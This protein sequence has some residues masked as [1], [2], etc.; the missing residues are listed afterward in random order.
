MTRD[1]AAIL[2]QRLI[3]DLR[4]ALVPALSTGSWD[5]IED[6]H[7]KVDL[8]WRADLKPGWGKPRYVERVLNDLPE[9]EIVRVGQRVVER[10]ADRPV[11]AVEHA[12]LWIAARGVAQV[13][14]ITR[15]ALAS[16]L[17]GQR[18]HPVDDPNVVLGRFACATGT[19]SPTFDYG[20][21][22]DLVKV[23]MNVFGILASGKSSPTT[24]RT[25]HRA[26]LDAYGFRDWPDARLFE[27]LEFLVN[28]TVR[29]GEEQSSL[30]KIL[31]SVLAADR[32]ELVAGEQRLSGHPVFKV[33]PVTGGVTGRPKNL[34]FA[35]TG[36]KPELGF[37][38]AVNNDIVILRHAE[39]CLVYDEPIGDDG[40]RWTRLIEWWSA[41]NAVDP[42]D[43]ATRSQLGERL[44]KSLASEPERRLFM[45]YFKSLRPLL[46]DALPALIPQVYLHYDP[47]TL[48][49]LRARGDARRFEVQ[50]MDFLLLLPHG[51]RV[52]V[53]VDGQQHYSTGMDASAKPSPEEYARTTR[54]DRHLRLAGYEVY[55]FGGYE[56]RDENLCAS[57]VMEFFTRLFRR[58]KLLDTPAS[59]R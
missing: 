33:R 53:E 44:R 11:L 47:L 40:L 16:A 8:A 29:R 45:S 3:Q 17:D 38:D 31:N 9:D 2:R 37:A 54:S 25:N 15:L 27:F 36:P 5:T 18:L 19:F 57:A 6:D 12:L 21:D 50:R 49:E 14:E 48:R 22:A 46:G 43:V 1:D 39:Y 26:L 35:S 30:V 23:E 34:I 10:L 42:K 28:P 56:L 58:H 32:F 41:R 7:R 59:P 51:V 52:I 13:S 55:R 4:A 24:T 20:Q